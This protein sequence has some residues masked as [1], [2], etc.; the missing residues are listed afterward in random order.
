[1]YL[2]GKLV[3]LNITGDGARGHQTLSVN[4]IS[5]TDRYLPFQRGYGPPSQDQTPD[6]RTRATSDRAMSQRPNW[7]PNL[8][9]TGLRRWKPGLPPCP[10]RYVRLAGVTD[11]DDRCS[12]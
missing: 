2:L 5:V 8:R 9:P 10:R 4:I 7:R 11:E 1:M 6:D 3:P 12:D